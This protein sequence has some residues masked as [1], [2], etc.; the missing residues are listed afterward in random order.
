MH[1]NEF[2]N[3]VGHK[4]EELKFT[5]SDAVWQK[6]ETQ[7]RE[8]KHRRRFLYWWLPV[9]VLCVGVIGWFIYTLQAN[10]DMPVAKTGAEKEMQ[11]SAIIKDSIKLINPVAESKPE[12]K[13]SNEQ[14]VSKK[15]VQ[16]LPSPPNGKLFSKMKTDEPVN[17]RQVVYQKKNKTKKDA[18]QT[19]AVDDEKITGHVT[20]KPAEDKTNDQQVSVVEPVI[21]KKPDTITVAVKEMV[22]TEENKTGSTDSSAT[23]PN[24][25]AEAKN[26]L[27]QTKKKKIEVAL[28]F[29][30][31]ISDMSDFS[32]GSIN[33]D[34]LS[35]SPNTSGPGFPLQYAPSKVKRG[36]SFTAGIQLKKPL[37]KRSAFSLALAYSYY[38]SSHKT[39]NTVDSTAQFSSSVSN[40]VVNRFERSGSNNTY[41]NRYHFIELPLMYHLQMNKP[42]KRP[43]QFNTGVAYSYLISS[44]ALYYH[45]TTG[46][47]YYDPKLFNRSQLQLRSGI[48]VGM[49][50]KMN[51]PLQLGLQYQ[52]GLT[53]QWKKSLNLNQHL[54]FTGIQLL[55]RL[56]KK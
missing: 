22:H 34:R 43:V 28:I 35:A 47:Y 38:S 9:A 26:D 8:Q 7:I 20:V 17:A 36:V 53:G 15:E 55:W 48:S 12:V 40:T 45:S 42:G 33:A 11:S 51:Y 6:V 31:G 21:E 44:N 19:V 2:E 23:S 41:F 39:G 4:L 5:P 3:R 30:T 49:I 46:N 24:K 13:E 54:S 50:K 32:A 29:K 56:N 37:T 18:E 14:T 27:P 1:N 10:R 25:I 52:Y 16:R